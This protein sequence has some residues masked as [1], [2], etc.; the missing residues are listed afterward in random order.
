M[1]SAGPHWLFD[2]GNTR[3]KWARLHADGSAGEVT[4]QAHGGTGTGID[5]LALP[6]GAACSFAS[7][8]PEPLAQALLLQLAQH[9]G[10]VARVRTLPVFDGVR[11]AYA[12]PERLGVDR[13]LALLGARARDTPAQP[14][15]VVGVGTALIV[16]LLDARGV[17]LGGRIA[18]SPTLMREALH[19]RARQLPPHGGAFRE[20]AD[21]TGDALASGCLG[22]AAALV[23][24]SHARATQMLGASPTVL[25]H[26]G[27]AEQLLPT[28][29]LEATL[30]PALV[31]QGLARWVLRTAGG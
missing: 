15:L 30:E 29:P 18:P 16:D 26:G 8:A 2:L 6:Q 11:I 10:R 28:L 1:N 9:F 19:A 24:R 31:V 25:L 7:V 17:H 3:L 13:F 21:D 4:A 12:A 20:F 23:E 22:A 5:S 14:A 27:G